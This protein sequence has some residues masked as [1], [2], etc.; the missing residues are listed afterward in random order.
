MQ[1]PQQRV[2]SSSQLVMVQLRLL[3]T[4]SRLQPQLQTANS[5]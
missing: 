3:T 4:S 5:V 1:K 2:K